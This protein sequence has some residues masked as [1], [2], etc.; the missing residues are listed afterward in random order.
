LGQKE[1]LRYLRTPHRQLKDKIMTHPTS[2]E[3]VTY[4]FDQEE[5]ES[6]FACTSRSNP[7]QVRGR[8]APSLAPR[9]GRSRSMT[10]A[11]SKPAARR[12]FLACP[13]ETQLSRRSLSVDTSAS[14]LNRSPTPLGN[15]S[16]GG[17]FHSIGPVTPL[18]LPGPAVTLHPDSVAARRRN[19]LTSATPVER[20]SS[21]GNQSVS[22][23]SP[24]VPLVAH[25]QSSMG[26]AGVG[27]LQYHHG[28]PSI[29][30]RSNSMHGDLMRSP[31][32]RSVL[33]SSSGFTAHS[34]PAYLSRPAASGPW[35]TLPLLQ[36]TA[37]GPSGTLHYPQQIFT[38]PLPVLRPPPSTHLQQQAHR[39]NSC[40]AS[41]VQPV[42]VH[43][44]SW[45]QDPKLSK[46]NSDPF[47][48][49]AAAF[50]RCQS[51]ATLRDRV[52]SSSKTTRRASLF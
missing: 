20:R 19:S 6:S 2:P 7:T 4:E 43:S 40:G 49:A 14:R 44:M 3:T 35:G 50:G 31:S 25:R 38:N 51:A 46:S 23:W 37:S 16:A 26:S 48:T 13:V 24:T 32:S 36:P 17:T 11:R 45:V 41:L 18:Q 30:H 52:R 42:Y 29:S 34:A 28:L 10:R 1:K 5:S 15:S 27:A 47:F 8:G 21:M 39:R 12:P 22:S 33:S 9:R